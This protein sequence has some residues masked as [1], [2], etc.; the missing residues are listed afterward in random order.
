MSFRGVSNLTALCDCP[1]SSF[2][3]FKYKNCASFSICVNYGIFLSFDS[4][5]SLQRRNRKTSPQLS[6]GTNNKI[7]DEMKRR[8]TWTNNTQK[9]KDVRF[10]YRINELF[11]WY[12][13]ISLCDYKSPQTNCN[14][15]LFHNFF[16]FLLSHFSENK[17]QQKKLHRGEKEAK[18]LLYFN[19]IYRQGT[20][21][22]AWPLRT[23]R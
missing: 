9:R 3:V 2:V 20:R 19:S 13:P 1:F 15:F 5:K 4:N 16:F 22:S 23:G 18:Q 21:T 11:V 14:P 12:D 17:L 7:A 6:A 10:N 8:K